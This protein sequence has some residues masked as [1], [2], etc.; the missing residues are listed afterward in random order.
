M[1]LEVPLYQPVIALDEQDA[2]TLDEMLK[3]EQVEVRFPGNPDTDSVYY[4]KDGTFEICAY[5]VIINGVRWPVP[6]NKRVKIP[7]LVYEHI[8]EAPSNKHYLPC[9]ANMRKPIQ[10]F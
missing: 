1:V 2:K 8:L 5:N 3:G 9:K 7:K 6:A 10:E 4:H